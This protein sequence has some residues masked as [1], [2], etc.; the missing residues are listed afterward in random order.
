MT[1]TELRKAFADVYSSVVSGKIG[2]KEAAQCNIAL[3][4][5]LQSGRLELEFFKLTTANPSGEF[6]NERALDNEQLGARVRSI[7]KT[8]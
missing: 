1:N 8:E 6:W 2:P 3:N 7:V 4:G 5:I